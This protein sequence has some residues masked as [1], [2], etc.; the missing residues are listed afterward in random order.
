M[1]SPVA[2]DAQRRIK[3]LIVEHGLGPGDPLPTEAE[4]ME[5]FGVSRNS[6]REALKSLQAQRIVEIRH[7]FGTYVGS[8][9]LEPLIDGLAFRTVVGH[10]RGEDSLLELLL[11]REALEAGLMSSLVGKLGADELAELDGLVRRMHEEV[12][13]D[14]AIA[15]ATDRAFHLALYGPLANRLLSE[16]L[17]A[18]WSA[19]HQS[20]AQDVGRSPEDA[21][22]VELAR[23]HGRIVAAVRAGD[24]EA[25]EAAVHQHFDD[26]RGRLSRR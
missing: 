11:L 12:A 19:F 25:A 15:A 5:R 8:M 26:I 20:R 7:G 21:D 1:R 3:E 24:A 22:G 17:D 2:Q 9:S 6:L 16:L 14:G 4:L 13:A 18:F 10:R 23:M